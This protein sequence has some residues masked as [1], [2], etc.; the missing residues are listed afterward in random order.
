MYALFLPAPL[1][2]LLILSSTYYTGS[3][4]N[5][6][7]NRKRKRVLF[8]AAFPSIE[9]PRARSMS[10]EIWV[11]RKGKPI[12]LVNLRL[13]ILSIASIVG[14]LTA[15]VTFDPYRPDAQI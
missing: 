14:S 3:C 8:I 2:A 11:A 7:C 6:H 1:P 4:S 13:F 12:I 15:I 9:V 10:R 5:L